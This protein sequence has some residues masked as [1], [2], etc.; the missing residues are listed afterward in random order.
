MENKINNTKTDLE[1]LHYYKEKKIE[2]ENEI[3]KTIKPQ[4]SLKQII[5][6]SFL[7][8]ITCLFFLIL[9]SF[10]NHVPGC[11]EALDAFR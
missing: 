3:N 10:S 6:Y 4:M 8:L 9:A 1:S 2:V 5:L 7:Y 11:K